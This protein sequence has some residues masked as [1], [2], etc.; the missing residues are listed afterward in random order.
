MVCCEETS[1]PSPAATGVEPPL[2]KWY[3]RNWPQLLPLLFS[4]IMIAEK[5]ET[6]CHCVDPPV[7]V[8]AL[9]VCAPLLHFPV[10]LFPLVTPPLWQCPTRWYW[11]LVPVSSLLL[12]L[13]LL[14]SS[15]PSALLLHLSS[16]AI[17]FFSSCRTV[18]CV[19]V[20]VCSCVT[21]LFFLSVLPLLWMASWFFCINCT[22]RHH[23]RYVLGVGQRCRGRC[24]FTGQVPCMNQKWCHCKSW[25]CCVQ[26]AL[27]VKQKCVCV[28]GRGGH[29][30]S[31]FF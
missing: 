15:A 2:V 8:V 4:W 1:E 30:R 17:T 3:N 7:C 29:W 5:D 13:L 26:P 27:L 19:C 12:L 25:N 10:S 11:K 24:L 21:F 18:R 9:A 31:G 20:C 28:F 22:L 16:V 6:R 14:S 23:W